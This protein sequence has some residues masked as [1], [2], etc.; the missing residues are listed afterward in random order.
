MGW[1]G[2][3]SIRELDTSCEYSTLSLTPELISRMRGTD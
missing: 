2:R 1:N 3:K